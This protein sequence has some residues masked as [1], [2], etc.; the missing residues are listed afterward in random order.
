[1]EVA[2]D[3]IDYRIDVGKQGTALSISTRPTGTWGWTFAGEARWDA[4][5]L[6]SKRFDRRL[7]DRLAPALV[8]AVAEME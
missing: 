7:L 6:R 1:V 8:E 2:I 3:G 5:T 4:S